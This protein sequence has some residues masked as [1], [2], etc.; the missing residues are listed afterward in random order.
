MG[1]DQQMEVHRGDSFEQYGQVHGSE[2]KLGV[3]MGSGPGLQP[4]LHFVVETQ[5][6][7]EGGL[8]GQLQL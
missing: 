2:S 7:R 3:S 1:E 4:L 8:L 6:L 5:Q